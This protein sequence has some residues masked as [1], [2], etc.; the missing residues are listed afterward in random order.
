[1]GS[2]S[3]DAFGSIASTVLT[4]AGPKMVLIPDWT[5]IVRLGFLIAFFH[6]L[7]LFL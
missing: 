3:F 2:Q 6:I 1:V 4:S 5:P 7:N